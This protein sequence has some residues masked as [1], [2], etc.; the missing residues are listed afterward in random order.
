MEC[1]ILCRTCGRY[2]LLPGVPKIPFCDGQTCVA[3]CMG[4]FVNVWK[5]G[6]WGLDV[7]VKAMRTHSSSDLQKS[8]FAGC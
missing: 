1:L 4:K 2:T 5:G 3:F 8:I 7:A 6:H